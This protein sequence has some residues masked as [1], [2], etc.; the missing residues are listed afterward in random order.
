MCLD[1]VKRKILEKIFEY[2]HHI[3]FDF[4]YLK[5]EDY[6]PYETQYEP[7]VAVHYVLGA[8]ALQSHLRVQEPQAF[9]DVFNFVNAHLSAVRFSDFL[10]GNDLQ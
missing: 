5:S 1:H 10:P 8:D 4:L 7:G 6:G 3:D 9:V 2:T